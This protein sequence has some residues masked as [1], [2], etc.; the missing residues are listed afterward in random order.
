MTR[1]VCVGVGVFVC[2][3]RELGLGVKSG[4]LVG[5]GVQVLDG[6]GEGVVVRETIKGVSEEGNVILL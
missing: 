3:G 2:V 6:V 5:L 1:A 4:V